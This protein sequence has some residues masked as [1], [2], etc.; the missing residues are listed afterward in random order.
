[1]HNNMNESS[2]YNRAITNVS[3]MQ[4]VDTINLIVHE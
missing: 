1:M 4:N 2:K 3:A